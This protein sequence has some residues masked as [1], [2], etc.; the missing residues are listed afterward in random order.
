MLRFL[1]ILANVLVLIWLAGCS[2]ENDGRIARVP[3]SAE[4]HHQGQPVAGATVTLVPQAADGSAAFGTTNGSGVVTFGTFDAGDGVVPGDYVVI[5]SKIEIE[6][7][8][9]MDQ[10]GTLEVRDRELLPERYGSPE[11]SG[12]AITV[13]EGEQNAFS[14]DLTD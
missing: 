14:F 8:T 2:G 13:S 5:V 10:Y 1:Q 4:I 3:A 7:L 12:L 11:T 9:T 6:E